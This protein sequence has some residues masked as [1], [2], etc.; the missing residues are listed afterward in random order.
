MKIAPLNICHYDKIITLWKKD[1][2]IR[3]SEADTKENI[4]FFLKRNKKTNYIVKDGTRVVGTIL[5][6]N[7]GRRGYF[8]HVYIEEAY[9]NAG[10]GKRLV[11]LCEGKLKKIGITKIH[12]FV[13]PGNIKGQAF[14]EQS[15]FY[16]RSENEICMFSKDI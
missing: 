15:G 7:D 13:L 1:P 11:A 4:G 5:C 10:L 2:N 16:R 8:H 12:I 9:R 6:G 3:L 14:W